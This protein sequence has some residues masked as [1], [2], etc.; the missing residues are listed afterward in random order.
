MSEGG[1]RPSTLVRTSAFYRALFI[2]LRAMWVGVAGALLALAL[3]D[4][5]AALVSLAAMLVLATGVWRGRVRID[6]QG[7]LVR[8]PLRVRSA[9]WSE[10]ER[11]ES[12]SSL[13]L[14]GC[15]PARVAVLELRD[16]TAVYVH[17]VTGA[18]SDD[19]WRDFCRAI[20]PHVERHAIT[21]D[22][23]VADAVAKA[24]QP[25]PWTLGQSVTRRRNRYR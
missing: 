16:R 6:D 24:D 8:N 3:P 11:I 22:E 19:V 9:A 2:L 12:R 23:V 20:K 14:F 4:L 25:P 10:V 7:L 17:P 21:L 1:K 15:Y 18:D 5:V 13:L